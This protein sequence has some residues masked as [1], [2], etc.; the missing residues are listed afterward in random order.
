[1]S[2]NRYDRKSLPFTFF[3]LLVVPKE[4]KIGFKIVKRN[5][6]FLKELTKSENQLNYPLP[7]FNIFQIFRNGE[8][9]KIFFIQITENF[10][11]ANEKKLFSMP[12]EL[13]LQYKNYF[14]A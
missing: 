3:T 5:K 12:A 7:D 10:Y 4:P 14:K 6:T 8:K 2:S 1:M 9:T 11:A 13:Y